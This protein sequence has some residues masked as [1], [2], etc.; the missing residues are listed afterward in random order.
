MKVMQSM[1]NLYVC[2]LFACGI[3]LVIISTA[4]A[5]TNTIGSNLALD[6][7]SLKEKI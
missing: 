1:T 4:D 2:S 6:F 5:L 3:L 7:P